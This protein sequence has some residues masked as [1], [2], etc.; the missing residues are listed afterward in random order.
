MNTHTRTHTH[1]NMRACM[2]HMKTDLKKYLYIFCGPRSWPNNEWKVRFWEASIV[3]I[4]MCIYILYIW[5]AFGFSS[6]VHLAGAGCSRASAFECLAF[7]LTTITTISS[8][9]NSNNNN[10]FW[11]IWLAGW[12]AATPCWLPNKALSIKCPQLPQGAVTKKTEPRPAGK[13]QLSACCGWDGMGGLL[14]LPPNCAET[15]LRPSGKQLLS[16]HIEASKWAPAPPPWLS[17]EISVLSTFGFE[18][19]YLD[20][21]LFCNLYF[22]FDFFFRFGPF[23]LTKFVVIA[24]VQNECATQGSER[25]A[26]EEQGQPGPEWGKPPSRHQRARA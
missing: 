3:S 23:A 6:Q 18:I 10:G 2:E 16:T 11:A 7:A 14:P 4:Y 13:G 12:A 8:R 19:I 24:C 17:R 15:P 20:I 26:E 25:W 9:N 21:F 5:F 1:T 22:R